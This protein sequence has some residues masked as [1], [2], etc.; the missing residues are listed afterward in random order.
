MGMTTAV[1]FEVRL[2]E[3]LGNYCLAS[4]SFGGPPNLCTVI[5]AASHWPK[6]LARS[7]SACCGS[8]EGRNF[9]QDAQSSF[10]NHSNNALICGCP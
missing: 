10:S 4:S 7:K 3:V 8:D 1:G 5:K 2:G 9:S 6:S